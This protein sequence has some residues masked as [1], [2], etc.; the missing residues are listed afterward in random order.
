[1]KAKRNKYLELNEIQSIIKDINTK[2]QKMHSGIHKRF[3]LFVAL[4]TNC[5]ALNGMR[6]GEM[7]AIQN[8]DIDLFDNKSLNINGT[9]HWF[10]DESGGFGVKDTTKIV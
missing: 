10:H 4:V 6:I 5:Q 1:M 9:I 8:E 2:A 7:L 3:Y